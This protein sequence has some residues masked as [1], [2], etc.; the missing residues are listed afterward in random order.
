MLELDERDRLVL[1]T[2]HQKNALE[3][4]IF[5]SRNR[6]QDESDSVFKV[7]TEEQREHFI[8]TLSKA[9]EWIWDGL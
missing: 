3:S 8:E 7:S 6:L 5:E 2:A 9:E 1:E 4:Y